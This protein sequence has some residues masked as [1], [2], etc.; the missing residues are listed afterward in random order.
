MGK[1]EAHCPHPGE[2]TPLNFF[3]LRRKLLLSLLD[4]KE[5]F[6]NT[7]H[8]VARPRTPGGGYESS[9][10]KPKPTVSAKNATDPDD[11]FSASYQDDFLS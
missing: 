7:D 9:P 6:I 2:A 10:E 11:Q 3:G 5:R 4:Y 8:E 1:K